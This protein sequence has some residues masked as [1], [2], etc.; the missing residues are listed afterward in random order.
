MKVLVEVDIPEGN[1]CL[2]CH[3]QTGYGLVKRCS[4]FNKMLTDFDRYE[5][6][7]KLPECKK[8]TEQRICINCGHY[9][10]SWCEVKNE[11]KLT[12]DTCDEFQYGS[13]K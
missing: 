10:D 11:A 7:I 12:S 4:L 8:L 3:L 5:Y 2:E 13:W 9:A 6:F 1:S